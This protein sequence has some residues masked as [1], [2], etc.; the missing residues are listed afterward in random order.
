MIKL[1]YQCSQTGDGNDAPPPG[2]RGTQ[3]LEMFALESQMHREHRQ[4]IETFKAL[5][6]VSSHQ[7]CRPSQ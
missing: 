1:L 4:I 2:G 7:V 3:S 6:E 5:C